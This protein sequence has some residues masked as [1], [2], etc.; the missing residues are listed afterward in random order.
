VSTGPQV[1]DLLNKSVSELVDIIGRLKK[2]YEEQIGVLENR[3]ND[4]QTII[5]DEGDSKA[6]LQKELE[7][8]KGKEP[9]LKACNANAK[10][11]VRDNLKPLGIPCKT[12][13]VKSK[14]NSGKEINGGKRPAPPLNPV[15]KKPRLPNT[16]TALPTNPTRQKTGLNDLKVSVQPLTNSTLT[17]PDSGSVPGKVP[18]PTGRST[19]SL[20]GKAPSVPTAVSNSNVTQTRPPKITHR[21]ADNIKPKSDRKDPKSVT[22]KPVLPSLPKT[23][24]PTIKEDTKV[25]PES[26]LDRV[27][28]EIPTEIVSPVLLDP[29]PHQDKP[30]PPIQESDSLQ[31][32]VE[33]HHENPIPPIPESHSLQ[34]EPK[35]VD[36][37]PL[38]A[39]TIKE[40]KDEITLSETLHNPPSPLEPSIPK[41]IENVPKDISLPTEEIPSLDD[42]P[43]L[44][45][46]PIKEISSPN[47]Y[48]PTEKPV[49]KF[50]ETDPVKTVENSLP[51]SPNRGNTTA[52]ISSPSLEMSPSLF[53]E[54]HLFKTEFKKSVLDF[55]LP[56]PESSAPSHENQFKRPEEPFPME[57]D[58]SHL[59]SDE[60]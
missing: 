53:G 10:S 35:L 50:S 18:K 11:S 44:N 8:V 37:P 30:Q 38:E 39:E 15:T 56:S 47:L 45:E 46:T 60:L 52:I 40:R 29:S 1:E 33:L 32:E 23:K 51:E 26:S 12:N 19:N 55:L 48:D 17:H 43:N 3:V 34:I 25:K 4:L 57:E 27:C 2:N 31:M 58:S 41:E 49:L 54:D 42:Q 22:P 36:N 21:I 14:E 5:R 7:N 20:T 13:D 59:I 24:M 28:P 6:V 16:T 9:V